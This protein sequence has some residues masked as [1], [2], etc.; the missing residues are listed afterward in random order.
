MSITSQLLKIASISPFQTKLTNAVSQR[1]TCQSVVFFIFF[2]N[3][4][5]FLIFNFKKKFKN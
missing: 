1:V 5:F 4:N 3:F 2:L